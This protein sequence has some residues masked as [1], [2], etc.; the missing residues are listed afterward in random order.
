MTVCIFI[1]S[2]K[3]LENL[4]R[5]RSFLP[6]HTRI[7]AI[8]AVDLQVIALSKILREGADSMVCMSCSLHELMLAIERTSHGEKVISRRIESI[9]L[10]RIF[11]NTAATKY[12][13]KREQQVLQMVCDGQ[14][15]K[16]IAYDLKLSPHTIQYYHRSVMEKV[17][18]NRTADLIVYAMRS[19]LY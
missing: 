19:G 1:D 3:D 6:G 9:L 18:V 12:L 15:I 7:L 16:E 4:R 13:T 8:C 17:G 14:T 10:E 2:A 5:C 11:N